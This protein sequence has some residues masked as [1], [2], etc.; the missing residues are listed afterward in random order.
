MPALPD[1]PEC[2]DSREGF[3]IRSRRR[4]EVPAASPF[5][6][7]AS[8]PPA[9]MRPQRAYGSPLRDVAGRPAIPGITGQVPAIPGLQGLGRSVR[10]DEEPAAGGEA[11][12]DLACGSPAVKAPL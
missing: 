7:N 8:L 10:R 5:L 12:D 2:P 3:L 6:Y 9:L 11:Q 4:Y 1:T